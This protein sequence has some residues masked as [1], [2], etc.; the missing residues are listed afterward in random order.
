MVASPCN[1]EK[2]TQGDDNKDLP[3][4]MGS[5]EIPGQ[6]LQGSY[7][8]QGL[9]GV[10]EGYSHKGMQGLLFVRNRLRQSWWSQGVA[11]TLV[12]RKLARVMNSRVVRGNE[13]KWSC[14]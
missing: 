11:T 5:W 3:R 12:V 13:V 6:W 4:I 9:Q 10:S 8:G 1:G 2:E 14:G 7:Q